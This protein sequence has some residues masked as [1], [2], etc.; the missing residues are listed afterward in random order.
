M[1]QAWS[2]RVRRLVQ[3]VERQLRVIWE[4]HRLQRNEL[5]EDWVIPWV[6]PI[7]AAEDVWP[8]MYY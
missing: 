6:L 7:Y 8:G 3:G 2:R 1:D 5:A 4:E